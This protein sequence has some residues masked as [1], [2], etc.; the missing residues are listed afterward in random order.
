MSDNRSTFVTVV[1]WIFIV[2]SGYAVAVSLLQN[3]MVHL[4]FKQEA[5]PPMNHDMPV[6]ASFMFDHMQL[7]VFAILLVFITGL[8]A[9]IGLL[10]RKNWARI[11][12]IVFLSLGILWSL[13]TIVLQAVFFSSMPEMPHGPRREGFQAMQTIMQWFLAV[14][15]IGTVVLFGWIVKRLTSEPVRR[16]FMSD[17]QSAG[18]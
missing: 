2:L 1:A 17:E 18:T 10:K 13:S 7:V 12:F 6:A 4:V 8:I 11:I 16:E 9:S 14:F 15:A 3:V 5:I